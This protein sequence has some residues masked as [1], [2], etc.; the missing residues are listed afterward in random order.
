MIAAMQSLAR[1]LLGTVG[2]PANPRV[3]ACAIAVQRG[4]TQFKSERA[5]KKLFGVGGSMDL[6]VWKQ[7]LSNLTD[8]FRASALRQDVT[9]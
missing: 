3:V 1:P 8:D 5:A 6:F 4:R 2:H 7:R 9:T